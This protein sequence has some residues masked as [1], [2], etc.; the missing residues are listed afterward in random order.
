MRTRFKTNKSTNHE[1]W[2]IKRPLFHIFLILFAPIKT[3]TVLQD[4]ENHHE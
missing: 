1:G 3:F 2:F 4:Q